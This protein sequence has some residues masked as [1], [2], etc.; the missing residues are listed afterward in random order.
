MV[1]HM[2]MHSG[3]E[4]ATYGDGSY[5]GGTNPDGSLSPLDVCGLNWSWSL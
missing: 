4:Q 3:M 5:Q 2:I 1:M